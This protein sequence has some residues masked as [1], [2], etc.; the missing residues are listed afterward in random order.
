MEPKIFMNAGYFFHIILEVRPDPFLYL[1]LPPQQTSPEEFLKH[2]WEWSFC[3]GQRLLDQL[4]LGSI[5]TL[6]S[7]HCLHLHFS[8][9]SGE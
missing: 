2:F 3:L 9:L 5:G 4:E 1:A 7:N 6:Q 8:P